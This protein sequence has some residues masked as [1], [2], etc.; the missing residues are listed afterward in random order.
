MGPFQQTLVLDAIIKASVVL[1]LTALAAASLRRA[2]AAARH[3]VWTLGLMG[4]LVAPALSL[5]LPRWEV[6]LVRITVPSTVADS[7]I[8]PPS[9]NASRP[10]LTRRPESPAARTAPEDTVQVALAPR[11]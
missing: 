7:S 1:G 11:D 2:S 8:A 4:A 9:T 5:A 10:P 6:P 3:L